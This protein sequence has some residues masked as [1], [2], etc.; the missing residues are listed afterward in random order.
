MWFFFVV[1]YDFFVKIYEILNY[2]VINEFYGIVL[3]N[4]FWNGLFIEMGCCKVDG[5]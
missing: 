2:C 1:E 4:N 3:I 5:L